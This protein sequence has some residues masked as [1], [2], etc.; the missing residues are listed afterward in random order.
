M[1]SLSIIKVLLVAF[2]VASCQPIQIEKH[3]TFAGLPE[4]VNLEGTLECTNQFG[5]LWDEKT[6]SLIN[7]REATI[8]LF[9]NSTCNVKYLAFDYGGYGAGSFKKEFSI[10]SSEKQTVVLE[11]QYGYITVEN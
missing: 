5:I 10:N 6:Q 9:E 2:L 1:K 3:L 4:D 11:Q 8:V 7:T